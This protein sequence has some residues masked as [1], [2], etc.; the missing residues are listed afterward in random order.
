MSHRFWENSTGSRQNAAF[1]TSWQHSLSVLAA[2]FRHICI[3]LSAP[4]NFVPKSTECYRDVNLILYTHQ[5]SRF[6]RSSTYPMSL[7]WFFLIRENAFCRAQWVCVHQRMMLYTSIYY[8]YYYY[9]FAGTKEICHSRIERF[10]G[11][12]FENERG[13]V[14]S[15]CR[16]ESFPW[17]WFDVVNSFVCGSQGG[18]SCLLLLR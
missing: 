14:F 5:S 1:S 2:L 7:C 18:L 4:T 15:F 12:G 3:L 6:F 8:Y 17:L 13:E 11:G 16:W 9:W 10:S